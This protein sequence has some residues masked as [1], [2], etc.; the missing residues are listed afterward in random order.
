MKLFDIFKHKN[1]KEMTPQEYYEYIIKEDQKKLYSFEEKYANQEDKLLNMCG[2]VNEY[3]K[4]IKMIVISDTHNSL[5]EEE[6]KKFMY[7][8]ND[9]DVCL[10]LGD[11][12]FNDITIILK[13]I[14]KDKI[15]GLLGNHDHS[16]LDEFN[17]R[18]LN[19]NIIN[20]NGTTILGIE[21]S[22][23]YKPVKFPSFTQRDSIIFLNDIPSVDILVSHDGGFDS[24]MV[25]NPAHQGLFGI[26]YYLFKNKVP[27]HIHGHLHNSYRKELLN[28]TKEISTYMYEYIELKDGEI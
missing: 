21:G 5:I 22:F 15:Y 19:G 14:D 9:Y 6:F 4:N 28:G 12:N 3:N 8:H 11:H 1:K 24:K 7:E 27:Y 25:N 16:Y 17:I 10:L 2:K 20:I 18:N 26:T 23:K 13:Y